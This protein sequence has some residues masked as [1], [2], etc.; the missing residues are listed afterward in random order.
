MINDQNR[1][2]F[3]GKFIE[4]DPDLSE[5]HWPVRAMIQLLEMTDLDEDELTEDLVQK[6]YVMRAERAPGCVCITPAGK[7]FLDPKS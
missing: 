1:R 7:Q 2:L 5:A 6:G 4:L 3:L